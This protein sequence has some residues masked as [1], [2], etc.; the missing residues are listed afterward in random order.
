[1][2]KLLSKLAKKSVGFIT[3]HMIEE[4]ENLKKILEK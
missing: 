1:M 2:V 3:Q 4:G